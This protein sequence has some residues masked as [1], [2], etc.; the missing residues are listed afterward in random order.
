MGRG[1]RT[2]R[3]ESFL[4]RRSSVLII[5]LAIKAGRCYH[6]YMDLRTPEGRLELGRRIHSAI[7]EAGFD[8]LPRFAQALGCSRAL[9]YQYVKGDVLVQADR[10]QHIGELTGKSLEWFFTPRHNGDCAE[11]QRLTEE[12]SR[13]RVRVEELEQ[14]LS[15]SRRAVSEQ[16]GRRRRES[17]DLLRRLWLALR[18]AG[19]SAGSLEHAPR[20][21]ELARS[22]DDTARVWTLRQLPR[23][24]RGRQKASGRGGGVASDP[25]GGEGRS[26]PGGAVGAPGAGAGAGGRRRHGSRP[27]RGG[28]AGRGR[29]LVAALVGHDLSGRPARESGGVGGGARASAG[30]GGGHRGRLA[31][32]GVPD[33]GQSVPDVGS[34]ERAAGRRGLSPRG[35]GERGVE[36]PGRSGR[37]G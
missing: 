5:C 9:I 19:D 33:L 16:D 29:A 12:L 28:E 11:T 7:A 30:R 34:G 17:M 6:P 36:G 23:V 21:R 20:W 14:A 27:R 24:V 32:G 2:G 18:R 10:L 35:G 1:C 3:E 8:S 37:A 31:V 25:G 13:A 4:D 22:L 15:L 26:G